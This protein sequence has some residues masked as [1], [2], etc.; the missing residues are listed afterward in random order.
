MLAVCIS[1]QQSD[2]V[3]VDLQCGPPALKHR[4]PVHRK[5]VGFLK[6]TNAYFCKAEVSEHHF[7]PRLGSWN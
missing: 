3:K 5:D 4:L 2:V 6:G 1:V 7:T